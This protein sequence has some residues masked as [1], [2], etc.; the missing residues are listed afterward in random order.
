[1]RVTLEKDDINRGVFG[2][3]VSQ[4]QL[5]IVILQTDYIFWVDYVAKC[6]LS[7]DLATS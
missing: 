2:P 3:D 1:M 5:R 7:Q 4:I 6:M